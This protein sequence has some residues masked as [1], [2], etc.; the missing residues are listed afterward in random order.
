MEDAGEIVGCLGTLHTRREIRGQLE[1]FCEIYGWYVK[2]GY[3]NQSLHLLMPVIGQRRD[4]TLVLFTASRPVYELCKKFGFQDLETALTLFFP[5]PTAARPVEI[6]TEPWRVA[7]Y[8]E[9]ADLRIFH[10][11]KD[12]SCIH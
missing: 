3:R 4:K 10:D 11:H 12:V 7:D 1:E 9:G 8:L 5:L 2:S 6:V